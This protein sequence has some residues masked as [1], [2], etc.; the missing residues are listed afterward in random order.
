[1]P[2]TVVVPA[3]STAATVQVT[4]ARQLFRTSATLSASYG[5]ASRSAILY[6]TR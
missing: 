1:V 2:A 5:R 4:T 3:G 6:V